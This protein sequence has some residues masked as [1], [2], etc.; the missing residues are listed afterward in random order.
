[1]GGGSGGISFRKVTLFSLHQDR[2]RWRTE[3]GDYGGA[4]VAQYIEHLTLDFGTGHDPRV[5]G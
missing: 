3:V 2:K 4:W 5:V 1:M